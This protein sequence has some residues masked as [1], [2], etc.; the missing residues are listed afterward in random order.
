MNEHSGA[1]ANYHVVNIMQTVNLLAPQHRRSDLETLHFITLHG[2]I[3]D[4]G[5]DKC[6]HV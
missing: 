6:A 3:C 2:Y 4:L 1:G 5:S